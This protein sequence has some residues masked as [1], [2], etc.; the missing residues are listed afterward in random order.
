[1]LNTFSKDERKKPLWKCASIILL[2]LSLYAQTTIDAS[3]FT[4]LQAAIDAAPNNSVV[5]M[6]AG[7]YTAAAGVTVHKNISLIGAGP[8]RTFIVPGPGLNQPVVLFTSPVVLSAVEIS[9]FTI[10]LDNAPQGIGLELN[11]LGAPRVHSVSIHGGAIGFL[12]NDTGS[13]HFSDLTLYDQDL[14]GIRVNGDAG[15]EN[16]WTDISIVREKS[17]V[18]LAGFELLRTNANDLGGQYLSRVRVNEIVGTGAVIVNGFRI[19]S[20]AANSQ[21][22]LSA[23]QCVA[24]AISGGDAWLLRNVS[25]VRLVNSWGANNAPKESGLAGIRIENS[26]IV[27]ISASDFR[28]RSQDV[29]ITGTASLVSFVNN[30]FAGGTTNVYLDRGGNKTGLMFLGNRYNALPTNDSEQLAGAA[31]LDPL[32]ASGLTLW[33]RDDMGTAQTLRLVNQ[34]AGGM[35]PS[36]HIRVN[37]LGQFEILNDA[38]NAPILTVDEQGNT[39]VNHLIVNGASVETKIEELRGMIGELEGRI[40]QLLNLTVSAK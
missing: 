6:P 36:K 35:S 38:G 21:V 18:L 13:G 20:T 29:A 30:R 28:S 9:G 25:D 16:H 14:A 5:Q 31:V 15:A 39:F 32:S 37:H 8:E 7:S 22:Y 11:N 17:G 10:N 24:D 33:T 34:S 2:P 27:Q 26:A 40:N 19:V 3:R 4:T 12:V 1:M 23:N